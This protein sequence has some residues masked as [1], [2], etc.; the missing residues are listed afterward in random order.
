MTTDIDTA[1][2]KLEGLR[3]RLLSPVY[4]TLRLTAGDQL[5]DVEAALRAARD[6]LRAAEERATRAEKAL[7]AAWQPILTAPKDGTRVLLWVVRDDH[8]VA[9]REAARDGSFYAPDQAW[10]AHGD[11]V[12]AT[13]WQPLPAPPALSEAKR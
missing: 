13:H 12:T 9:P 8:E 5:N 3:G 10:V 6:Q 7:A 11:Y 1:I 4:A 2:A